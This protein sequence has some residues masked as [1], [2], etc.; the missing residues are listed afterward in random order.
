MLSRLGLTPDEVTA[1]FLSLKVAAVA[2]LCSLPLGLLVAWLL[3][4]RRFPGH[5][6]LDGLVHLPLIL[7]PVVTGYLLLLGFGRRGV[8]GAWLAE[9]G[10]VFSFRWTGAALACAVM[11]FPLMVRAMRLSIEAVDGKLEQAAGTL[12][13]SPPLVFL[14]VTLAAEPARLPCR[15]GAGLRQGDGRVRRDDHLRLEHPRRDPNPALGHL[16]PDP[17][18]GRGGG[19]APSHPRFRGGLDAGPGRVR[20]AGAA[21]EPAAGGGLMR[22]ASRSGV[23]IGS[24]PRE[25]AAIGRARMDAGKPIRHPRP[26]AGAACGEGFE[27]EAHHDVGRGEIRPAEIGALGE[28]RFPIRCVPTQLRIDETV[29]NLP[30]DRPNQRTEQGGATGSQPGEDEFEE[31]RRHRRAL[32]IVKIVGVAGALRAALRRHQGTAR[33]FGQEFDDRPGLRDDPAVR[34]DHGRLAQGM[35]GA[36]LPRS[37]H[38][39][40]VPLVALHRI[41]GPE[42]FEQPQHPLR[43]AVL[44][45]MDGDHRVSSCPADNA[46]TAPRSP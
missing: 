2:T 10:I 16:H 15:S 42:F 43:A 20:M 33:P 38:R 18:A 31:Q 14:L 19:R 21:H 46:A 30:G 45:V 4:R 6:L 32:G 1:L 37:P 26:R 22:R 7:P 36:Q 40:R 35:D 5:A 17:G 25:R 44:Q 12:G 27:G 24:A 8:F 41:G 23:G 29:R 13:A 11:G 3:A 39:R 34:L 9:I 28:F